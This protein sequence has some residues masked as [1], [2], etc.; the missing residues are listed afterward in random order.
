MFSLD[1]AGI[2][3][4]VF[5]IL[6]ILSRRKIKKTDLLL[7]LINLDIIALLVVDA[8]FQSQL[9]PWIFLLLNII[10][11]Y[12]FPLF[13]IYALEILQEKFTIAEG[14][15]CFSCQRLFHQLI[16]GQI[17]LYSTIIIRSSQRTF[18]ISLPLVITFFVKG[19]QLYFQLHLF[20]LSKG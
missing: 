1:M 7:S 9:T 5:F 16:Q 19:S 11:V 2:A 10:P 3:I 4:S 17:S 6:F 13:L 20:G 12:F 8:M 14:G 15:F 18:T